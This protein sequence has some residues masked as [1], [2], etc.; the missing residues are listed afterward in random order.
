[1]LA[2]SVDDVGSVDTLGQ[3]ADATL[4]LHTWGWGS[5]GGGSER[6]DAAGDKDKFAEGNTCVCVCG[7]RECM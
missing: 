7:H 1:M 3:T 4:D 2:A 5:R 6:V